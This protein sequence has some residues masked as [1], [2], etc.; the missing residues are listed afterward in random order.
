MVAVLGYLKSRKSAHDDQVNE[1]NREK[2]VYLD[3]TEG[4]SSIPQFGT[5]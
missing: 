3:S 2:L 5:K 4:L 1:G